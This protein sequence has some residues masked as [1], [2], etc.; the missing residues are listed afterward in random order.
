MGWNLDL[1]VPCVGRSCAAELFRVPRSNRKFLHHTWKGSVGKKR[2]QNKTKKTGATVRSIQRQDVDKGR[3]K[4]WCSCRERTR[5]LNQFTMEMTPCKQF[6]QGTLQKHVAV[7]QRQICLWEEQVCGRFWVLLGAWPPCMMSIPQSV[8]RCCGSHSKRHLGRR[9]A[10]KKVVLGSPPSKRIPVPFL[11]HPPPQN[12]CSS[13]LG[14]INWLAERLVLGK[15]TRSNL[16]KTAE[17]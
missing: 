2:A 10:H 7:V 5:L 3:R 1:S 14:A 15:E 4:S 17:C 11:G 8:T 13:F 16:D 6:L 9:S 12:A